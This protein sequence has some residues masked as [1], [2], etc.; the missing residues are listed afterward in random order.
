MEISLI[1]SILKW[2]VGNG[3]LRFEEAPWIPQAEAGR[4]R[5]SAHQPGELS[6]SDRIY[7]L[8]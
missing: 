2:S 6:A 1:L 4:S 5:H 8:L 7:G 3:L